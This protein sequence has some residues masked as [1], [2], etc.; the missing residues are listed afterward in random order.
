MTLIKCGGGILPQLSQDF[1]EF[2]HTWQKQDSLILVHGGGPAISE[3][4]QKLGLK[5]SFNGRGQRIT[6]TQTLKLVVQSLCGTVNSQLVSL[7]TVHGLA[8]FGLSGLDGGLLR[9]K[10]KDY[11]ELGWVGEIVEVRT[12]I[13]ENLC[14]QG[15]LPVVAPVS[16]QVEQEGDPIAPGHWLNVNA[17]DVASAIVSAIGAQSLIFVSNIPGIL[18]GDQQVLP[19]VDEAQIRSMIATGLIYGGM[20]PKV[21]GALAVLKDQGNS[22]ERVYIIDGTSSSLLQRNSAEHLRGTCIH[23]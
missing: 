5:S 20:V 1:A 4:E 12:E 10:I 11:Q 2:V 9:A 23:L 15:F 17:D 21:E 14:Q 22:L 8:A 3:W 19:Q 6:D 16:L 7:L 13:L 18:D